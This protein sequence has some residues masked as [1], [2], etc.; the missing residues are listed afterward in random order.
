MRKKAL[1]WSEVAWWIIALAVIALVSVLFV[2]LKQ[3]GI[4]LLEKIKEL[5]RFG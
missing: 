2:L 4:N 3:K 5:L 1:V